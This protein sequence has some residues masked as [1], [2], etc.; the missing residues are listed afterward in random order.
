MVGA[1]RTR[2]RLLSPAKFDSDDG[3]V[4]GVVED[5]ILQTA[6]GSNLRPTTDTVFSLSIAEAE[7]GIRGG[8]D[9]S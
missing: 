7:M 4:S 8:D 3:E 2:D 1:K 5:V 6:G 9:V